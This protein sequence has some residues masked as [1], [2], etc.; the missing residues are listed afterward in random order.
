[1]TKATIIRSIE[2][3][4]SKL[5]ELRAAVEQLPEVAVDQRRT[6]LFVDKVALRPIVIKAFE[7][8]GLRGQPVGPEKVQEMIAACGVQAEANLFSRGIIEARQE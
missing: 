2:E 6:T 4:G 7:Q 3:I 8:M 1:M 5:A